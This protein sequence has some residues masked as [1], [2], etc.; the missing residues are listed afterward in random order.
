MK[1]FWRTYRHIKRRPQ[2]A[3]LSRQ[4][5]F[6]SDQG[7]ADWQDQ[8]FHEYEYLEVP[9]DGLSLQG[10]KV[11]C[12]KLA[13]V[14][15]CRQEEGSIDF[16]LQG[17]WTAFCTTGC[18]PSFPFSTRGKAGRN[19]LNEEITPLLP[20]GI[21]ERFSQTISNLGHAALLRRYELPPINESAELTQRAL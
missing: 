6:R 13:M 8:L 15:D 10:D 20:T 4:N 16:Q 14:I 5:D 3:L 9:I 1:I 21:G 19:H 17:E 11:A 12:T 7:P 18:R 2:Q